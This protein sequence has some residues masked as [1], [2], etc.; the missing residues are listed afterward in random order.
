MLRTIKSGLMIE[1]QI[2]QFQIYCKLNPRF[3]RYFPKAFDYE[4][5]SK[6][7]SFIWII[8]SYSI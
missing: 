3:V 1:Y 2:D 8:F 5:N 6:E 7:K 4:H